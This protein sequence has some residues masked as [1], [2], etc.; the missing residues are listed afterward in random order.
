MEKGFGE[1]KS[2]F[3]LPAL[4]LL[5]GRLST[6]SQRGRAIGPQKQTRKEM[7]TGEGPPRAHTHTQTPAE[8][9]KRKFLALGCGPPQSWARRL[10]SPAW[11]SSVAQLPPEAGPGQRAGRLLKTEGAP[12]PGSNEL[13]HKM[14]LR[15]SL[16]LLHL[17]QV[18]N[19]VGF[20]CLKRKRRKCNSIS[21]GLEARASSSC[22][23]NVSGDRVPPLLRRFL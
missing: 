13:S 14:P 3:S 16:T 18:R 5:E 11:S 7:L 17:R 19:V 6:W 4:G 20:S 9:R 8:E 2:P 15:Q 23:D 22:G 21:W 1:V 12:D 10:L